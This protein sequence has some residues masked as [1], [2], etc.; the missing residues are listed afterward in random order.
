MKKMKKILMFLLAFCL[1]MGVGVQVQAAKNGELTG[2]WVY[3]KNYR[4]CR[5]EDGTYAKNTWVTIKGKKYL[6]NEKGRA[7]FGLVEWKGNTYYVTKKQGRVTGWAN[8]NGARYYFRKNGRMVKSQFITKKGK[9]YYLRK[10]GKMAKGWVKSAG[11]RYYMNKKNGVMVTGEQWVNGKWRYFGKD[12]VY[13]P[14]K[15]IDSTVNPNKPMV[16]LTFDDGPGPYTDRLLNTLEKYKAKATFFLVGQNISNYS[17]VV[18]R[19]Y[20]LGC[21]IGSHTYSHPML[22]NLSDSGI[23]SEMNRTNSLIKSATGKN[24]TVM[25]PPYGDCSSRVLAN[26]TVPAIMWSIDTRDWEHRNPSR[27]ISITMSRVKDGSIILMHD[28]H[29]PSVEAAESLIPMLQQKGYQLVTVSEL[30]KY[31]GKTLSAGQKYYS[32]S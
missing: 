24:A 31:R 13:D 5:L 30:A 22:T 23:Q 8:V 25:R 21:E 18:K 1:L 16:A 12:G 26:L 19:A 3:R 2:K 10:N 9:T 6:F 27:T 15:K 7:Q 28:I 4:K 14:D 32:I 20:R 11:K 17:S 29:R